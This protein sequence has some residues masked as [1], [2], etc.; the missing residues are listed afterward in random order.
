MKQDFYE[1]S[2]LCCMILFT[3]LRTRPTFTLQSV[4]EHMKVVTKNRATV[5]GNWKL[6]SWD[7][8]KSNFNLFFS[9]CIYV[10]QIEG[11][12]HLLK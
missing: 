8:L 4:R 1:L 6:L 12:C 10:T 11:N 7:V 9:L 5:S 3:Q 2:H